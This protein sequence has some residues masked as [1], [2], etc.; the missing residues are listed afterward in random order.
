M[1]MKFKK[2]IT[3]INTISSLILQLLS[4]INGFIIPKLILMY[5]GSEVNGL[6][7]SLT[8]FLSYV[9]LLE[10]GITGVVMAS[11]Y[12]PLTNNDEKKLSSIVNTTIR[13]YRKIAYI[14]LVYTIILACIYPLI[15]KTSFSYF[16]V[17]SLTI[18][19]SITSFVQY[20][21]SLTM[22]TLLNADKKV[23]IV[24]LTQSIL[25]IFNIILSYISLIIY[26]SVHVFK[27]LSAIIFLIQPFVFNFYV[28]KNY[29]LDKKAK[30]DEE[31]L[32]S[33]WDGFSINMAAFI[34]TNTD[35]L[36]LSLFTDMTTVSVYSVYALVGSGL[37]T[38]LNFLSYGI[39][40][41]IGQLYAKEKYIEL[42]QKMDIYEYLVFFLVFLLFS[43]ASFLLCPF[44]MTYT[45]N[46]TD[47]NYYQP[48][49]GIILMLSEGFNLIKN[50][51]VDL[52]YAAN[53]FKEIKIPCYIEAIIN[54]V[55]SLI[56]IKPLGLTGIAIGTLVAMIYRM[57]FHV[58]YTNRKLIK[59]PQKIFYKKIISF[60]IFT[61]IGSLI[62]ILL[63]PKVEY[64]VFSWIWHGIIYSTIFGILYLINSIIFYKKEL[65]GIKEYLKL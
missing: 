4:I 16:Y 40:P 30:E 52:A 49:F 35:I 11:L 61:F 26:P 43:V 29:R 10:G 15:F 21:F 46:I 28:K 12:K 34:H 41:T 50:A 38:I 9:A 2:N 62:C 54:I 1:I 53:K 37:R 59:R 17:F 48:I 55:I 45:K 33:R 14:F 18:I 25:L 31:L 63:I 32:K 6:V 5:F 58:W 19:L 20:S 23:Y 57:I 22:K 47:A 7:S 60:G 56:L 8:K 27:L 51:H 36:L 39:K 24:S 3:L 64:T 42:D 65:K 44:V 13:F